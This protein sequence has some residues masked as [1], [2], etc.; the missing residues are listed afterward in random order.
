[1]KVSLIRQIEALKE[2]IIREGF[3]MNHGCLPV[4]FSIGFYLC[5]S[6]C[7]KRGHP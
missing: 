2:G 5:C 7:G 3:I 1:M 4:C 6:S